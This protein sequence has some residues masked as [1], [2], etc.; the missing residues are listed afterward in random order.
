MSKFKAMTFQSLKRY[1]TQAN[2][3]SDL[4]VMRD[5]MFMCKGCWTERE[6]DSAKQEGII[7]QDDYNYLMKDEMLLN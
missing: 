6:L 2:M 1:A 7:D 4:P 3:Q 5:F